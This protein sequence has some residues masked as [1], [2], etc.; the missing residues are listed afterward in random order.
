MKSDA[1]FNL[2]YQKF[3]FKKIKS[4]FVFKSLKMDIRQDA[5]SLRIKEF[6]IKTMRQ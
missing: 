1:N 2:D 3:M 6:F 5:S 4:N